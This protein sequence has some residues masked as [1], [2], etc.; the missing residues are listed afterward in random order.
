MNLRRRYKGFEISDAVR[1]DVARTEDLWSWTFDRFGGDGPFLFGAYTAAD[2]F[3]TPLASR[4]DTYDLPMSDQTA[5]YVDALH[6][7]PAFRRWRAMA[8]AATRLNEAYEFAYERR[9]GFG[10]G[11]QPLPASRAEGP[12]LNENCPYSG[13]P[14]DTGSIAEID[15]LK[16]GYCNPFCRDKSV[17]D[18]EAWPQTVALMATLRGA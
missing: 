14:V 9:S 11:A 3:F 2:A 16:I 18:A 12:A 7:V 17:A 13:K 5:A 4:L 6:R 15:G 10:P 8:H 1:A